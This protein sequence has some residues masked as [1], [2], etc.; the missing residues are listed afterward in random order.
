MN[1]LFLR[2]IKRQFIDRRL[3]NPIC[4]HYQLDIMRQSQSIILIDDLFIQEYL[5]PEPKEPTLKPVRTPNGVRTKKLVIPG[6]P[7]NE[8]DMINDMELISVRMLNESFANR[9]KIPIKKPIMT[10]NG[11]RTGRLVIPG[12]PSNELNC[13]Y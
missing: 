5:K 10:P 7:E 2:T 11:I 1:K 6:P 9:P 12:P 4:K 8:F 3:I 13:L